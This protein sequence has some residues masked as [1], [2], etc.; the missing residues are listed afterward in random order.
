MARGERVVGSGVLS[1]ADTVNADMEAT[2]APAELT[3]KPA[4]PV[5]PAVKKTVAKKTTAAKKANPAK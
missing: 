2:E 1:A 5:K 3:A 4:A